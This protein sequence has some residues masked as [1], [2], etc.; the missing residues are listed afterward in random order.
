[1]I[2]QMSRGLHLSPCGRGRPLRASRS[3]RVRGTQYKLIRRCAP[4]TP[5]LSPKGR[6][7]RPSSLLGQWLTPS[8]CSFRKLATFLVDVL[9]LAAISTLANAQSVEEFYR[10]KTVN[11]IIG[12]SVG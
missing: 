3:G 1:M 5:T 4:L 11:M 10:G 8:R 12:Y 2:H 9:A 6:G 7:S